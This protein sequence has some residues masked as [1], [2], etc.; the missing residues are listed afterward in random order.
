[1]V[2][3]RNVDRTYQQ[4]TGDRSERGRS[5][6]R[7]G[8]S[9]YRGARCYW[10]MRLPLSYLNTA[11]R[12]SIRL[13]LPFLFLLGL[14]LS[15]GPDNV[16][17]GLAWGAEPDGKP[18]AKAAVVKFGPWKYVWGG[19]VKNWAK[20]PAKVL[21]Q[22][23][24][25]GAHAKHPYLLNE[26]VC[27]GEWGVTQG[28]LQQSNGRSAA[29]LLGN[30]EDFELEAA[31]NAE[32]LGG[33][34]LLFGFSEGHGYGIYNVNLKTSGS[35]WHLSEFRGNKGIESTDRE[36]A[37]YICRGNETLKVRIVNSRLSVQ[38]NRRTLIEEEELPAYTTGD[39]ILGTYDTNY[40]PKPLKIYGLR[41]RT[42]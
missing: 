12:F 2:G 31:V 21:E 19:Q 39:I 16:S 20:S 23:E 38:V 33:W 30:A 22:F 18:P 10:L 9:R 14:S 6:A 36:F 1:M 24:V 37:R 35:P 7:S 26:V 28:V 8:P 4:A 25:T 11:A 29:L 40:G 27:D 13:C 34:F 15:S 3:P 32:G 17:R 5:S 42:P 41:L